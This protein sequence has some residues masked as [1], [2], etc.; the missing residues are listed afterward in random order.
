VTTEKLVTPKCSIQYPYI[1]E[2]DKKFV[3]DGTYRVT[4]EIDDD[5]AW[6]TLVKHL[7]GRFEEYYKAQCVLA[8]KTLK[9]CP[10]L[11]WKVKDGKHYFDAK[12][13]AVGTTKE[14]RSFTNKPTVLGPD[15]QTVLTPADFPKPLGN[16]TVARVGFETNLWV[17]DAQGVG[18]SARLKM[19]QIIDPHYYDGVAAF[20]DLTDPEGGGFK[21]MPADWFNQ[22]KKQKA[23]KKNDDFDVDE[24]FVKAIDG[25]EDTSEA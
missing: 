10:H 8:N 12:V 20:Q 22:H 13:N 16:G 14:G 18:L 9:K 6:T 24:E 15:A 11:P 21:P 5:P 3:R 2:P 23:D 7:E 17:N 4:C 25:K 1:F 19:I